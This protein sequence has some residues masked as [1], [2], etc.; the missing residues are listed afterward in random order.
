MSEP[1]PVADDVVEVDL[2]ISEPGAPAQPVAG[3][4]QPEFEFDF[5]EPERKR[6]ERPKP[7]PASSPVDQGVAA[8]SKPRSK[9]RAARRPVIAVAPVVEVRPRRSLRE[10]AHANRHVL[11]FLG[12]TLLVVATV[13][14]RLR[15]RRRQDLP[16][17]AALGKTKGLPA[18]DAG[19]FDTAQRLLSQAAQ[20]V[21]ELGGA[22]EDS[23]AILQGASEAAI[24]V[25]LIPRTLEDLITEAARAQSEEEWREQFKSVYKGRA[26][27]LD[28]NAAQYRILARSGLNSS[29]VGRIDTTGIELV[30][31]VKS[32]GSESSLV[33]GARLESVELRAGEWLVRLDPKSI[34]VMKHWDAL[35]AFG[36]PVEGD[37]TDGEASQ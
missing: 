17:I 5:E 35:K 32:K 27:I 22:F 28:G 1:V 4:A 3:E 8:P 7:K 31:A 15:E 2:E 20:A 6:A 37:D 33:F 9:T 34:V 21:R 26:V 19:D 29:R 18:L 11:L 24:F 25:D 30:N 36:W 12:V 13:M 23:E 16:Q 14:Y 10:W